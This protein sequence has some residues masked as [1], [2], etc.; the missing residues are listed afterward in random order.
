MI[1]DMIRLTRQNTHFE[2]RRQTNKYIDKILMMLMSLT[3]KKG[4]EI[5]NH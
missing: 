2:K 3:N 5:I 1:Y 4:N